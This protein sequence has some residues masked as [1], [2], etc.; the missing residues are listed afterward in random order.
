MIQAVDP[1]IAKIL[2]RFSAK[3]EA[4][5]YYEAHQTLRTVANRYVRAKNWQAA[6][7]LITH[8]IHS[9]IKAG[10]SSEASDLT[11]YLLEIYDLGKFPC[12]EQNTGRLAE[13]I[14]SLDP[15]DPT[16]KDLVTGMNNWSVLNSRNKFGDPYLHSVIGGRLLEAGNVYEAERYLIMGTSES[17]KRYGDFI[18]EWYEQNQDDFS[19]EVFF[20]RLVFN[21]LGIY[22][23]RS[24]LQTTRSFLDKFIATKSP[25][26]ELLEKNFASVYY[27]PEYSELNFLQLLIVTCQTKNPD[28]YNSLRKQY[29]CYAVNYEEELAFISRGYFNIRA[30]GQVNLLHDM[31]AGFF[32]NL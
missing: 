10:Q 31:M 28:Y 17:A 11:R 32:N 21:F 20:S 9:F 29:E 30:N 3:V 12:D 13:I 14:N 5:D 26:Y 18:W 19:V 1:K 24:A 15:K 4:A 27:F 25:Q 7:E 6:V 2:S 8:G 22:N 16:I 23:I